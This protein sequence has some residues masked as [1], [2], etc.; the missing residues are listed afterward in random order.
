MVVNHRVDIH[1]QDIHS[2]GIHSRDI[3]SQDFQVA[4]NNQEIIRQEAIHNQEV[5]RH[6]VVVILNPDLFLQCHTLHHTIPKIQRW[7]DLILQIKAFGKVSFE[8]FIRF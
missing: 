4:F 2:Q 5:I 1:S 8:K 7:K 6:Q 3:H